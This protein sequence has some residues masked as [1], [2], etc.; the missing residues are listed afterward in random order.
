MALVGSS[1]RLGHQ[2]KIRIN[3]QAFGVVG[4]ELRFQ[5][6]IHDV[7]DTECDTDADDTSYEDAAGGLVRAEATIEFQHR[8]DVNVHQPPLGLFAG[9]EIDLLVYAD[10]LELDPY[11]FPRF[12][13]GPG[14][15][16]LA[17]R[18]PQAGRVQGQSRGLFYYPGDE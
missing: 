16:G 14:T 8:A 2:A 7:T 10:G 11:H 3:G 15:R 13:L 9:N 4:G 12:L 6:Q 17:L 5:V 18:S 1:V